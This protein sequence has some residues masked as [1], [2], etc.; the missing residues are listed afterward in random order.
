MNRIARAAAEL[1]GTAFTEAGIRQKMAAAILEKDFW[2]CWMLGLLFEHPEW[3]TGLVF[4][5]GTSLSKVFKAIRR[6]SEDIDLSLA[7]AML[8]ITAEDVEKADSGKKRNS[9]MTDLE[10]RC[11]SW[12]T[13]DVQP[14]LEEKMVSVLGTRGGDRP[15]LT[16]ETDTSSHSPV[17]YFHYPSEHADGLPYIR[18]AVKLEF[19][20]LTDQQPAGTHPVR[21]WVADSLPEEMRAMGCDVVALEIERTFW[22]KAT[23]LHAE[24]HRDSSSAMPARYSRHYS[25]L[26][27]LVS[28]GHAEKAIGNALLRQ[29]VVEWKRHF[30]PRAWARYDLAKPGTFRLL[31]PEERMIELEKDYREMREMFVDEPPAFTDIMDTLKTL[32]DKINQVP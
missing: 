31:P 27:S 13:T 25:D 32:E 24:Y 26:A 21:P 9:L 16:Y 23:I 2:V 28:S 7:P 17:L 6:F 12:V 5:G 22:E 10:R 30:F 15:W 8:G 19:G 29:R 4:K 1:R 3:R 11:S 20:S 18:R 14:A